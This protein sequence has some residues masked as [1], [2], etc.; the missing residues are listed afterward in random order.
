M[1][2][3]STV[4]SLR[5][6]SALV[7]HVAEGDGGD[8]M[9]RLLRV[10]GA[11]RVEVKANWPEAR[12]AWRPGLADLL[13]L[14]SMLDEPTNAVDALMWL[15]LRMEDYATAAIVVGPAT[16]VALREAACLE[17][18]DWLTP[19]YFRKPLEMAHRLAMS[20]RLLRAVERRQRISAEFAA[21][22]M[23]A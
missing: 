7:V 19:G 11:D 6:I 1:M 3:N 17:V 8:L 14:P 9:A 18:D 5:G 21:C 2:A 13:V 20:N 4:T 16:H 15:R 10:M 12:S 22:R 23:A